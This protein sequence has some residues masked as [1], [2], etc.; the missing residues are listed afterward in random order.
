MNNLAYFKV[1][2][3]VKNPHMDMFVKNKRINLLRRIIYL[4]RN[5]E[6]K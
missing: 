2:C 1:G 6:S 4:V 3:E 5:T